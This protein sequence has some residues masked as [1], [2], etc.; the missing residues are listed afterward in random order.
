MEELACESQKLPRG[1]LVV[2]KWKVG[3]VGKTFTNFNGVDLYIITTYFSGAAG[4]G[5]EA[6]KNLDGGRL[7]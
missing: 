4:G 5:D 3:Y 1:E 7:A 6:G 2:K